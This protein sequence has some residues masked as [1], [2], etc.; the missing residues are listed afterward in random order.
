MHFPRALA[1]SQFLRSPPLLTLSSRSGGTCAHDA[2]PSNAFVLIRT[3]TQA[4]CRAGGVERALSSLEA[5][6]AARVA[7]M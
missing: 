6:A 1:A 2:L 5:A 3:Q 4:S 7:V